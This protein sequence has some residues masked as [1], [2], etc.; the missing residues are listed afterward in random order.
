MSA[1]DVLPLDRPGLEL[2]IYAVRHHSDGQIKADVTDQTCRM[3]IASSSVAL[4]GHL[5]WRGCA[6]RRRGAQC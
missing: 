3:R 6:R 1:R 5:G 4:A 2:L